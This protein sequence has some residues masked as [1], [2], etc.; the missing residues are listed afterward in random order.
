MS[1]IASEAVSEL[2]PQGRL[3][4][5]INF[6]NSVL[7]QRDETSGAVGGVTIDLACELARRLD[8]PVDLVPF[9]AA[10]KV[11]EA[12]PTD[13]WDIAFLAIEPVRAAEIDFTPPYVFI[14][15][16]YMVRDGSPLREIGDV[17]RPGVRISVGRGSAYDLYLTR[18][19]KNATVVPAHTGGRQ[20]MIDLFNQD[21]LEVV[22]G[23]R[24]WLDDY[25]AANPGYRV[26]DGR[27]QEIRQ[28]MGMPKGRSAA[29]LAYLRAFVE[30][31]KASGFVADALKRSGR[32]DAAVAPAGD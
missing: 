30:E 28:A 2:A 14:E 22:A 27:F 7:A 4:A 13:V 31:M 8:V 17:D 11:F 1:A 16:T 10:G 32:A 23:V 26:M 24:G 15:G 18:T 3:R 20:A 9:E 6:G 5:A 25:A 29:T 12:L 21:N 19:I